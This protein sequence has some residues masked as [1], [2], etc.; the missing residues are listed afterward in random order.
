MPVAPLV[1]AL[2]LAGP[3]AL[4]PAAP[5]LSCGAVLT[6]DTVL[7][8]DLDCTSSATGLELGP[9]VTLDLGGHTVTGT[10]APASSDDTLGVRVAAEGGVTVRNGT[11]AGWSQ[12]LSVG[13]WG[14]P[15]AGPVTVEG[16]RFDRCT[17]GVHDPYQW[18]PGS[19][20]RL[21]VERSLL[22]GNDMAVHVQGWQLDVSGSTFRDNRIG[23]TGPGTVRHSTFT[24]NEAGVGL[25]GDGLDVVGSTFTG[26]R[27][28]VVLAG[29]VR[30]SSFVDNRV[31]VHVVGRLEHS[32]FR[33]ND[34]GFSAE[35]DWVWD[36]DPDAFAGS[37]ATGNVFVANHHGIHQPRWRDLV[38]RANVAVG[39]TGWGIYA[40]GARDDGH[41]VV[42]R[43]GEGPS[44]ACVPPVGPAP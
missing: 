30:R 3:L 24:G 8:H 7:T 2:A 27:S 42:A 18:A 13:A 36:E 39:N 1:A 15:A 35:A 10:T 25:A 17:K 22:V 34:K 29:S 23:V 11:L 9:G 21:T 41:N 33:G 32:L 43:N 20:H 14:E 44:C 37:R 26:N 38:L 5:P 31:G 16:V 28:G 12:C 4:A 19:T 40:P 6:S